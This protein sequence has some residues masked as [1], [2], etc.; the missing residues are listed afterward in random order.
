LTRRTLVLIAVGVA[1]MLVA[2]TIKSGWLYLVSSVLFSLVI[3]GLV[4]GWIGGRSLELTRRSERDAF[5]GESFLVRLRVR[6]G[7]RLNRYLLTV[8]DRGFAGEVNEGLLDRFHR[9]R[10]E[11]REFM[12]TGAVSEGISAGTHE[13]DGTTRVISIERIQPGEELEID[14]EMKASRRGVYEQTNMA[15]VSGGI[16]GSAEVT[17]KL[18]IRSPLTVFPKISALESFPFQ[19]RSEAPV[20][21]FEWSRKG[22]GQDYY[23]VR[24]YVRG[25][26]L[27]HIHWRSSARQGEL[28]VKEYQQ[29][30]RP[31]AGLVVL[32]SEPSEG[33]ADEN[34][35]EDGLRCAASILNYYSALGGRPLLVVPKG[36]SVELLED[37]ALF[38]NLGELAAYR[39]WP[40]MGGPEG[41]ELLKTAVKHAASVFIGG[42][43]ICLVT[44]APAESIAGVFDSTAALDGSTVVAVVDESYGSGWDTGLA[45]LEAGK[46]ETA[47]ANRASL[48]VMTG[49]QE[50]GACL[51]EPL[52]TTD[53]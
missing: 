19:P 7:G 36:D 39:A 12:R 44:N 31:S 48:F 15:V 25:D 28:I 34:S 17:R 23:G 21:A 20:E 40:A 5:E 46:L 9:R 2:A 3:L 35:L 49:G 14:Y 53:L 42:S 1:L 52:S 32:L 33:N 41:A 13:S 4:S 11:Y 51:S 47:V 18:Q 38:A 27:R 16:F 26:S 8:R 43:A 30:F 10:S 24:E 29:E 6:N 37:A 45:L 22:M 50:I